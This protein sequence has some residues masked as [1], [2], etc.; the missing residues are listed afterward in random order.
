[1]QAQQAYQQARTRILA[2]INNVSNI[3][4]SFDDWLFLVQDGAG[5]FSLICSFLWCFAL[6]V[7][8]QEIFEV[9][10]QLSPS[11]QHVHLGVKNTVLKLIK[12]HIQD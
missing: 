10:I 1:M 3:D 11:H 12:V 6:I 4:L 9:Y 8:Q 7:M 5:Y 2:G